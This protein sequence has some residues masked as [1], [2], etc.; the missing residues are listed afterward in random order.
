MKLKDKLLSVAIDVRVKIEYK[1]KDRNP[2][3]YGECVDA[4]L[5]IQE[6]LKK[7]GIE[8]TFI[9]GWVSYDM[10]EGCSDVPYDPHCW[11]EVKD[12]EDKWY[13]DVTATQFNRLMFKENK[14][15]PIIISKNM[16]YGMSYTEPKYEE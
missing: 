3:L 2:E 12:G 7:I 14:Y 15:Q 4:S 13:V 1:N 5:E 6:M 10:G 16:P 11:I 9:E 8:S